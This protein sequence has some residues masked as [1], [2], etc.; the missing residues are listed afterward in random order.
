MN[1]RIAVTELG[2]V[3]HFHRNAAEAFNQLLADESGMP[4]STAGYDNKASGTQKLFLVV[5]HGGKGDRTSVRIHTATH[6]V[7]DTV[8]LVKDFFQ[9]EVG[10]TS[11][12][13]LTDVQSYS[14]RL[15]RTLYIVQV[16]NLQR[17]I[18]PQYG[19]FSVREIHHLI[20]VSHHRSSIGSQEELSLAYSDN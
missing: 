1:H 4:G 16:D 3:F 14:L 5:G 2:G 13:Q 15:M 19:Y 6:T 7:A 8:G 12:F 20:G 18:C 10:E 9:H 11:F 17:S